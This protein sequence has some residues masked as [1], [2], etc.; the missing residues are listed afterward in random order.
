MMLAAAL[1]VAILYGDGTHD[2]YTALHAFACGLPV[3]WSDGSQVSKE[4]KE[5][6]RYLDFHGR[7]VYLSRPFPVSPKGITPGY[8]ANANLTFADDVDGPSEVADCSATDAA[9]S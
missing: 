7:T 1:A 8:Y 2:D 3:T 6:R 5:G 4:M 9:T